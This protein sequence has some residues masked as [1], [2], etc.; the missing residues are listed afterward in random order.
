MKRNGFT[1]IE[2]LVVVAIIAVLVAILLPALSLARETAR[3]AVCASNLRQLGVTFHQYAGEH[4][5]IL[6]PL[7]DGFNAPNGTWYTNRL[8]QYLPVVHWW[9]P[10]WGTMI[11]PEGVVWQCPSVVPPEQFLCGMGYGVN[12]YHLIRF[13][14]SGG[15]P[16]LSRVTRPSDVYL[17]G[18][19][20]LFRTDL[21]FWVTHYCT[22]CP[23]CYPWNLRSGNFWG[24]PKQVAPRH[25]GR[26]NACFVDGHVESWEFIDFKNNRKDIF[27]HNGF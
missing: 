16:S 27:A 22:D 25:I 20:R 26:G 19:S 13:S 15:S 23:V 6:P 17:I 4:N 8:S 5:D 10:P 21:E 3:S 9:Q 2:L 18:D 14:L 7:C 12:E 11:G 24:D 1:L